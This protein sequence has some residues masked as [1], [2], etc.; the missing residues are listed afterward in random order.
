MICIQ[1]VLREFLPMWEGTIQQSWQDHLS[2]QRTEVCECFE[3]LIVN[4][5]DL[6]TCD[7]GGMFHVI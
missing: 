7:V 6:L 4:I 3:L 1:E 2:W 5:V